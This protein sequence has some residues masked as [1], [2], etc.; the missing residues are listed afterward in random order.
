[1]SKPK[2]FPFNFIANLH[3][4]S[5]I[6]IIIVVLVVSNLISYTFITRQVEKPSWT[7]EF[8]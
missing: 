1:M 7:D 8:P 6:V 4:S 2:S 3:A 5:T